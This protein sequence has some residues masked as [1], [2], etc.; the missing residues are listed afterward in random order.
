MVPRGGG[1]ACS[2]PK[3]HFVLREISKPVKYVCLQSA[4]LERLVFLGDILW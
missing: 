3:D 1:E 4:L 2:L